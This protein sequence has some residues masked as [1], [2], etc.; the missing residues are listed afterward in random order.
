M[1]RAELARHDKE[2]GFVPRDAVRWLA[3]G[4][5]FRTAVQVALAEIFANYGDKRELQE[6]FSKEPLRLKERPRG[7]LWIDYTADLGDGF[8]STATVAALLSENHLTVQRP[9]DD[10]STTLP[11]GHLLVLGGDEVYPTASA[12]GYEDRTLGPYAAAL[13][14]DADLPRGNRKP[15]LL[16]LPG[17]HDWYDGLSAFLR[18]FTRPHKIGARHTIQ[19]RSYFALRLG[20]GWWLAGLDSQL[21]EYID[22][23]QLNYFRERLT[24]KLCPGDAI[25]LCTASPTW[26][27]TKTKDPNAFNQLHYFDKYFLRNRYDPD[28]GTLKPT[29]AHVRLWLSGDSHHYTRYEQVLPDDDPHLPERSDDRDPRATQF[30]TCGLGGAFLSSTHRLPSELTLPSPLSRMNG[31]DDHPTQF[32]R[33]PSTY[34]DPVSSRALSGRIANPF[35]RFWLGWRNLSFTPLLGTLHLLLFLPL[36]WLFGV[37]ELTGIADVSGSDRWGLLGIL[38]GVAVLLLVASTVAAFAKRGLVLAAVGLQLGVLGLLAVAT[39]AIPWPSGWPGALVVGC[40]AALA[41]IG[42]ALLGT[43]MFALFTLTQHNG[44]IFAWQ[45]SSQAVDDHKGFLRLRLHRNGDLEVFPVVID[46]VCR[47]WTLVDAPGLQKRPVPQTPLAPRLLEP[48][49]LISRK[50]SAS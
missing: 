43:E 3:P 49:I 17:N 44:E 48:P 40:A 21:G 15:S 39:I 34:P 9:G 8:D 1:K 19:T 25:I 11:R 24:N 31:T 29:G 36:V 41:W 2:L 50:G 37:T 30:I 13:P 38:A 20:H 28:E 12:L 27:H 7:D 14:A 5:L 6:V 10:G 18:I 22:E 42:G 4:Q 47:D 45:M 32:R 46:R 26:V 33:G 16:A 35:S 23:P